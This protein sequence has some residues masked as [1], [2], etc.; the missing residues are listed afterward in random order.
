ML[1]LFFLDTQC[2]VISVPVSQVD[3]E[4]D[5]AASTPGGA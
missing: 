2:T 4:V 5:S 3:M 1:I